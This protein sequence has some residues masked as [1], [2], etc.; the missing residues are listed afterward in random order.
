MP[1][2]RLCRSC[3]DFHDTEAAWPDACV[4]HFGVRASAAPNIRPDGMTPIQ[5][6]I[7]GKFHD[8]RSAYYRE[9]RSAGCEIVGDDKAGFG[10]RPEYRAD[11]LRQALKQSLERHGL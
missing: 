4:S 6:Q 11:G 3:K 2:L 9:V 5:S 10:K 7:S 1:R 8:S